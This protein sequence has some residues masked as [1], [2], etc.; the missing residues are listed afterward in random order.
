MTQKEEKKIWK[1]PT[2]II[3]L[4]EDCAF[5]EDC[6]AEYM[7]PAAEVIADAIIYQNKKDKE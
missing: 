3:G 5:Y 7:C 1:I 6:P 2:M 4:C